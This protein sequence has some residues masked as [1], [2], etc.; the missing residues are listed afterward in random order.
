MSQALSDA[1]QEC[2]QALEAGIDPE[3]TLARFPKFQGE[4]RS[5]LQVA[6]KYRKMGVE[7]V[8]RAAQMRSRTLMLQ[9]RNALAHDARGA[10]TPARFH[11]LPATLG[12][13]A[14][15]LIVMLLSGFGLAA[16]S[17]QA[18]PGDGLYPVKRAAESI[19]LSITRGSTQRVSLSILHDQRRLDEVRQLL[20]A[21]RTLEVTF[22]A[23]LTEQDGAFWFF[24]DIPVIVTRD[25]RLD[26]G[27]HRGDVMQVRGRT[28]TGGWILASSIERAGYSFEGLVE[29]MVPGGWI[30]GGTPFVVVDSTE[31]EPGISVGARVLVFAYDELGSQVAHRIRL[32]NAAATPL[33]TLELPAPQ[34]TTTAT[35]VRPT[36]TSAPTENEGDGESEE[37]F[38]FSGV[39]DMMEPQRWR[40]DGIWVYLDADTELD[41]PF[42]TGYTVRAKG[43]IAGDGKYEAE[44]IRTLETPETEEPELT[45]TADPQPTT[46]ETPEATETPKPED[47]EFTGQVQSIN[48]NSWVIGGK[49]V[50]VDGDTDLEGDPQVGDSVQV[51]G[52]QTWDGTIY[53]EEI[54]VEEEDD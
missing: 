1:L 7:P 32:V 17:A 51:T 37:D 43:N 4:L 18:L 50:M 20:A 13:M 10:Q 16:A 54:E 36:A 52:E 28:T 12:I 30:V 47:I 38:D 3:S 34:P 11:W 48:G 33:P 31:V 6:G 9:R 35:K 2:L 5:I 23:A 45:P 53:A 19:R 15:I 29:S 42:A 25:T 22:K 40:I 49:T 21:G 24:H 39:I 8:P 14:T 41:G 44:E 46:T 26:D 27:L